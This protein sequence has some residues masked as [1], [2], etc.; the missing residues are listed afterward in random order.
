[1]K[2]ASLLKQP[3][4]WMEVTGPHGDIVIT[5]RVRLARNVDG[6]PFPGWARKETALPFWK[7]SRR[8]WN[9]LR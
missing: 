2:F 4:D 9:R 7:I 8:K 1:M 3:A 6:V 5:S